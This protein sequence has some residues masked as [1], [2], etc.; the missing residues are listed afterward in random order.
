[1]LLAANNVSAPT[2]YPPYPFLGPRTE[3]AIYH[4]SLIYLIKLHNCST[5][6]DFYFV[7]LHIRMHCGVK[8]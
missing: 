2:Y 7:S 6:I 3:P 1:M 5:N 8:P 4:N